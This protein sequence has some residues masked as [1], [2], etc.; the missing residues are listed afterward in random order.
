MNVKGWV[1]PDGNRFFLSDADYDAARD[2][3]LAFAVGG[4]HFEAPHFVFYVR[5]VLAD[6]FGEDYVEQSGLQV[7]TTLDLDLQNEFQEIVKAGVETTAGLNVGNGALVA[8]EPG[9]GNILAMVGSKD[10][11]AESEPEGCISG[12][13]GEGGCT[14]DPNV[15]VTTSLRQPGSSFKPITYA[16]MLEQGYTAA[17]PFLDVPTKF[18]GA[19]P[20]KPYIPENYDG[21]YRGPMSLRRSLANSLNIPAVKALKIAGIDNVLDTAERLG[22]TT[23]TERDRYG[24]ALT[25]GGGET[26][27]LEMTGAFAT[28]ANKGTFVAPFPI[29]EVKDAKGN[30]VYKHQPVGVRALSEETAFLISDILSDNGAR[31]AV[32][33]P[34]SLLNIS[35]YEVAVKTGTTDDLR[36][37]Y[38][39]G[40]TPNIAIG[41][42]VG[43]NNN[44]A[45]SEVASGITGATPIWHNAITAYLNGNTQDTFEPPATVEKVTV[46]SLTG[47]LPFEEYASRPEWIVKGTE[48]TAPSEWYQKLEVCKFDDKLANSSCREHDDTRIES[49]VVVKAEFPEWQPSVDAWIGENFTGRSEYFPPKLTSAIEYDDDGDVRT[50]ADPKVKIVNFNDGDRAPLNFRLEVEVSSPNDIEYVTIYMDGDEITKDRSEPYGYNFSFG[51]DVV[52][53]HEFRAK[54]KDERGEESDHKIRLEIVGY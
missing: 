25:L 45:M 31:S 8:V 38:A 26:K 30:V 43:N 18:A 50:K 40:Y 6:M 24:L 28:F 15:N 17:F 53:S 4:A 14:F 2:E 1:G 21:Y 42:W 33:G 44:E 36:D 37:N 47:A 23:L 19:S 52:G 7:I 54:V 46:D 16:T 5:Q 12:Q 20:D 11:F 48:P 51:S 34:D 35:G 41:V 13:A 49:Y 39:V 10:Y 3:E 9:T 32:F 29:L 22:I 27:L